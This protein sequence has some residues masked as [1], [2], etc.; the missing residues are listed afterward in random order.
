MIIAQWR[1]MRKADLS[2]SS[3]RGDAQRRARNP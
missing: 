1:G 2:L 3:F